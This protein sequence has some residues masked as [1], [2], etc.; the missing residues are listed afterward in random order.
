MRNGSVWVEAR[1][2]LFDRFVERT[3]GLR[4]GASS[5]GAG[6]AGSTPTPAE[7]DGRRLAAVFAAAAKQAETLAPMLLS[8]ETLPR[9]WGDVLMQLAVDVDAQIPPTLGR[10]I[11][12]HL[13]GNSSGTPATP[14]SQGSDGAVE[15]GKDDD[16]GAG[17]HGG[18]TTAQPT[19][20][21]THAGVCRASTYF[22][23]GR[24]CV[25]LQQ[26]EHLDDS[27]RGVY[28]RVA[29]YRYA[30]MVKG[31]PTGPLDKGYRIWFCPQSRSVRVNTYEEAE[32]AWVADKQP[33]KLRKHLAGGASSSGGAAGPSDQT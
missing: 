32:A 18:P 26:A 5:L 33:G 21:S 7:L 2:R 25:V 16:M 22:G 8:A 3:M 15:H 1:R 20:K 13:D 28:N 29:D 31:G 9:P 23:S 27:F 12:N 30:V 17:E 6:S 4:S 14:P 11:V 10:W 24:L 19:A